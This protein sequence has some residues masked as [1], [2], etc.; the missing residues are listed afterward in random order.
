MSCVH[1][2]SPQHTQT[3][4]ENAGISRTC[5]PWLP[6]GLSMA[7]WVLLPVGKRNDRRDPAQ[8][9]TEPGGGLVKKKRSQDRGP[10][11]IRRGPL[12]GVKGGPQE[13][14]AWH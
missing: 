10:P 5:L 11:S 3:C 9:N 13:S 6:T 8:G 7:W 1:G 2:I 14:T 4:Q 12:S